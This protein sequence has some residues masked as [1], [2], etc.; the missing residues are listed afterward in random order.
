MLKVR[1]LVLKSMLLTQKVMKLLL[2]DYEH[3][4]KEQVLKP[5]AMLLMLKVLVQKRLELKLMQKV[6]RLLL[7]VIILM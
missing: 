1:I 4:V 6:I 2:Q 3:T 5:L 7:M